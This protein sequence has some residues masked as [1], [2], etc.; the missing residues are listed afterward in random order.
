MFFK[1]NLLLE[2]IHSNFFIK[3]NNFNGFATY[4][5]IVNQEVRI[6]LEWKIFRDNRTQPSFLCESSNSKYSAI[7][8]SFFLQD[9]KFMIS[10]QISNENSIYKLEHDYIYS[11][12]MSTKCKN[13]K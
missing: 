9:L 12:H 2:K 3:D 7:V 4:S 6:R 8:E 10:E 1:N 13:E 11:L 5:M